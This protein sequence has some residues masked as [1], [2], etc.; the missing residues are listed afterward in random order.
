MARLIVATA[1]LAGACTGASAHQDER[2]EYVQ[3]SP[4]RVA[5][6][7]HHLPECDA[8]GGAADAGARGQAGRRVCATIP[9]C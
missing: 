9:A 1:I 4:R 7:G 6:R 2:G 5:R 3:P 8:D